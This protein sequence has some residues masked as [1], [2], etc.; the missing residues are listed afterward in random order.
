MELSFIII[1]DT[2]LDHFIARKMITNANNA[3]KVKSFLDATQALAYIVADEHDPGIKI[4][5]VF[6][7]IYMPLMNGFEFVEEFE[8][9]DKAIQDK[10]YIVALTSSIEISDVNRIS[11]YSA[12]K[13]KITKPLMAEDIR[14]LING[15]TAKFNLNLN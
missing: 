15:I 14:A 11:S 6:L 12:V 8:K 10:Y 7:D 5:L 13:E 2:E 3:F 4:V 1:D 9:L